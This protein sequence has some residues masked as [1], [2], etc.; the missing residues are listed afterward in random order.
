MI[1]EGGKCYVYEH[2]RFDTLKV[3]Y[4]GLG[5]HK[6]DGKYKKYYRASERHPS[7]RNQYW[8]NVVNKHGFF[9]R[10]VKD[11]LTL[12]QARKFEKDLIELYGLSNLC[13]LKEG[14]GPEGALVDRVV[15]KRISESMKKKWKDPEFRMERIEAIKRGSR[16]P[17]SRAARS[18]SAK[19]L[20]SNNEKIKK[21]VSSH[22]KKLWED[23]SHREKISSHMKNMWKDDRYKDRVRQGKDKNKNVLR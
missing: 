23:K 4:V 19:E 12:S 11:N 1:K 10:I 20:K 9:H 7:K 14:G 15:K 16:T 3:F 22:F 18:A 5:T 8:V 17:E 21:Q 6:T 13:N 2:Y